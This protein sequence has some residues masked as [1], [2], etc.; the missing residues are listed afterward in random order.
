MKPF[1]YR[2]GDLLITSADKIPS[3]A[4]R[5]ESLTLL[6]GEITGHHHTLTRG[7]VWKSVQTPSPENNYL[8]GFFEVEVPTELTHQEHETV[9][10]PEGVY[11]FFQQREYDPVQEHT[12]KD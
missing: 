2:H 6:E 8:V 12:V 1:F 9:E 11:K 7:K 5:S 4:V 10:I 3:D